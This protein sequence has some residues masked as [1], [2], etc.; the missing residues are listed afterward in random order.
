MPDRPISTIKT[1][2]NAARRRAG[3]PR[4]FTFHSCRHWFASELEMAGTPRAVTSKLLGHKNQRTT[5]T[6][7]HALIDSRRRAMVAIEKAMAVAT[8][9]PQPAADAPQAA[10]FAADRN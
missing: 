2:F 3:L 1:A 6:Y 9:W 5:D 4:E 8:I 7:V 10:D